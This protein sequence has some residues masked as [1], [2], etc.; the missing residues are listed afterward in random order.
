VNL[1][2][3]NW[4]G[5][6]AINA[7]ERRPAVYLDALRQALHLVRFRRLDLTSLHTH[8][9]SLSDAAEAFRLA[10]ERPSGFIK[11]VIRP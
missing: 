4:K 9:W 1:Q 6:D 2:S 11:S 8:A 7:H 10:E 3:W 5:I